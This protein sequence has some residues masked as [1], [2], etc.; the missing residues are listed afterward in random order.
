MVTTL[1]TLA[2]WCLTFAAYLL[3]AGTVIAD[4]L[5]TAG[6]LAS[7][8]TLWSTI[9]PVGRAALDCF[10]ATLLA[11]TATSRIDL[12]LSSLS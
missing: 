11:M 5:A 9:N 10:V 4:E 7:L 1:A 8:A 3:F 2:T 12:I 6:V